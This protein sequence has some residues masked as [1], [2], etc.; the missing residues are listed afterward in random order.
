MAGEL[1]TSAQAKELGVKAPVGMTKT[2]LAMAINA[3]I[4]A[5]KAS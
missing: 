2:N 5:R 3:E 1:L 4:E